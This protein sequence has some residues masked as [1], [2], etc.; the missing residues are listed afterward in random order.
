MIIACLIRTSWQMKWETIS[1]VLHFLHFLKLKRNKALGIDGIPA[2]VLQE[3][4]FLVPVWLFITKCF[5][6]GHIRSIWQYGIISHI[7]RSR[8][9]NKYVP[10]NYRGISLLP[11]FSKD[12]SLVLNTRLSK[13]SE[14]VGILNEEQNEFRKGRSCDNV[15]RS[16]LD[17]KNNTFV[18][19]IDF[20]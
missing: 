4:S 17:G 13:Y 19:F 3:R 16:R 11:I 15:I 18:A 14:A 6:Y 8:D 1:V 2:H 9:K 20:E 5:E 10:L 7:P 12:Y